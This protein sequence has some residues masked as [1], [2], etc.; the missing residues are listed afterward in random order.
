MRHAI[1]S[2][3]SAAALAALALVAPSGANAENFFRTIHLEPILEQFVTGNQYDTHISCGF[4]CPISSGAYFP[5]PS[6]E[7]I[8][9][10][11]YV[12][13]G[14]G[15]DL[16]HNPGADPCNCEHYALLEFRGRAT[17][18]TAEIPN[19]FL[20]ATLVMDAIYADKLN[21]PSSELLVGVYESKTPKFSDALRTIFSPSKHDPFQ[22]P[23][24][25]DPDNWKF[26][27]GT[28]NYDTTV[29]PAFSAE[30]RIYSDPV[31]SPFPSTTGPNTQPVQRNGDS[32]RINVSS[33]VRNW[34]A[35]W[36]NRLTQP[37]H[38]FL[39]VA[40]GFKP[41]LGKKN[42]AGIIEGRHWVRYGV[43]LEIT[44]IEPDK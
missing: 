14:M 23:Y 5:V 13:M 35:D 24:R 36:P 33:I 32:Y 7:T 37:T 15:Y 9:G 3:M 41:E 30:A 42:A 8:D 25:R 39:M 26:I 16:F 38:G 17:F 28:L 2:T 6:T 40:R 44:F 29:L 1:Q 34:I 18:R 19:N 12:L 27:M 43:S 4:S 22:T 31:I 11:D 10:D 20:T 21:N